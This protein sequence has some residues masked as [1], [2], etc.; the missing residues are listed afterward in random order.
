MHLFALGLNHHSAPV[1]LRERVAFQQDGLADALSQLVRQRPVREAAILSTCNRT[2]L[3]C[4]TESPAVVADWL[5]DYHRVELAQISPHL[6]MLPR[7]AAVRHMFR[8]ASGLDSMVLGEPQI[9]G[10]MKQAARLAEE[11]GTLGTLLHKL[12]QRTFSVAKEVR[13]TTAIGANV[14]S[15]AAAAV[16]LSERIFASIGEQ[17]VLFVGAGEMVE[18]CAAHFAGCGPRQLT[19]ANRTLERAEALAARFSGDA[20]T[21]DA[22]PEQL[23]RY[24]VVVSCTASPLPIIGLGMVERA[25]KSRRHRPM[26]MV[27]L[28][29]PRDIEAEIAKLDDVF[30]YT[31]DD[32]AQVVEAGIE[33]RQQAVIDAEAIIADQVSQFLHWVEARDAVPAIRALRNRADELRQAELERALARLAKGE[34]PRAVIEALSQGLTNKLMH[35]PTQYLNRA[36][37]EHVGEVSD[38]VR[39][40]FNLDRS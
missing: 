25:L 20:I 8:V 1:T 24:D 16:R 31:V 39:R 2:E 23:G 33:S 27:D 14:V 11:A 3:Y 22:L 21:L 34:D 9:L 17:R 15:M 32:L 36:E 18:L 26:V 13:S 4:A 19:I 7:D 5:A 38:L 37:G 35:A 10:Q 12:F 40:L 30:L 6:F 28:A 29:V